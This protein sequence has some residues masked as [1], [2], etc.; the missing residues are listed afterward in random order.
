MARKEETQEILKDFANKLLSVGIS[1]FH[2]TNLLTNA[3][4]TRDALVAL[5]NQTDKEEKLNILL[6]YSDALLRETLLAVFATAAS[7]RIKQ[8]DAAEISLSALLTHAANG[9]VM[10]MPDIDTAKKFF[11]R[12]CEIAFDNTSS[13]SEDIKR[14]TTE[15]IME[16]KKNAPIQ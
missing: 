10:I 2:I 4:H 7:N 12:L 6:N 11:D 15:K 8:E 3:F 13:I 9:C 1:P 5:A 14:T 16:E